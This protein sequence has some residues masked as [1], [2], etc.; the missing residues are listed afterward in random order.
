MTHDDL[1]AELRVALFHHVGALKAK[2]GDAIPS[3]AL[4]E[5]MVFRGERQ[6]IWNPQQGIYKPKRLG[7]DGAALSIQTSFSSP[8]DDRAPGDN[9]SEDRFIYRYRGQNVDH[10]DNRAL[11]Q[12]FIH[13]RP[14][15]YLLAVEPGVYEA[16][17]P[18][19]VVADKPADLAF[20]LM[21][22]A[23]SQ[24]S[25][26]FSRPAID[27]LPLKAYATRAVRTRL[28]QRRFRFSVLSAY[29]RQCAMCR[30]K[31]EILL[32][33][34]HILPDRDERGLPVVSNGL[35]LCKIH[36]SAYDVGILGV[37]ADYR[38]HLRRDILD[39]VDGPMLK[40]GLQD[41][42][43]QLIQTPR[44]AADRPNRDFLDERFARFLAA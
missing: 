17:F 21:A 9:A 32:D 40:H 22:D 13:A 30:L 12:A 27:N 39:Q 37:S 44:S 43:G 41:M 19:Y 33:A 36:H 29:R 6:P 8:Y 11:R 42:H 7:R 24:F 23:P 18:F 25:P 10:P 31:H 15:L 38:V 14:I 20:E 2:Y 28:H 4:T 16:D 35:S 1:D 26:D 5:G 3:G 34:A